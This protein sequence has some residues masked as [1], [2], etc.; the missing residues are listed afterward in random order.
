MERETEQIIFDCIGRLLR[1][2]NGNQQAVNS[3]IEKLD[4][5]VTEYSAKHNFFQKEIK[6][7][8]TKTLEDSVSNQLDKIIKEFEAAKEKAEIAANLYEESSKKASWRMTWRGVLLILLSA[9][10]TY[11]FLYFYVPSPREI[12]R[13]IEQRD[14]LQNDIEQLKKS[15]ALTKLSTCDNR[16]C[17]RLDYKSYKNQR[18]WG[19]NGEV[20]MILDG[21]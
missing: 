15:G 18:T 14:V 17:V 2:A 16:T 1:Q 12:N 11:T 19:N 10:I 9:V 3:L 21:Y 20:Y 4:N 8:I 7:S 6:N 13:L 5:N